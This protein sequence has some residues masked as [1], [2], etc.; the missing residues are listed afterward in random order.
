MGGVV[1]VRCWKRHPAILGWIRQIERR[2]GG[3]LDAFQTWRN[4]VAW[5]EII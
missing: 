1:L 4:D 5:Y 3:K 2:Y